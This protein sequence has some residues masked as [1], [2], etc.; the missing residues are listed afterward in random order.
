[1]R[2]F[3]Y[4]KKLRMP[5]PSLFHDCLSSLS[6][7]Q[8]CNNRIH[9]KIIILLCIEI[10]YYF[11]FSNNNFHFLQKCYS[12]SLYA[13]ISKK[14]NTPNTINRQ[15]LLVHHSPKYYWCIFHTRLVTPTTNINFIISSKSLDDQI[16]S[17]ISFYVQFA[18]KTGI[19]FFDATTI[20]IIHTY[21][22][23]T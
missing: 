12:R 17:Y 6:I 20:H 4:F 10:N 14:Q 19:L 16:F 11:C 2:S 1:M 21:N 7:M 5:F 13:K 9:S 15:G 22:F 18:K 3:S 23:I 8:P